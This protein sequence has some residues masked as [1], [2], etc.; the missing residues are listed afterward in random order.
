MASKLKGRAPFS[1]RQQRF[2]FAQARDGTPW[3]RKKLADDATLKV[4]PKGAPAPRPDPKYDASKKELAAKR[5]RRRRG[6][7]VT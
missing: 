5:P 7:R 6:K 2:F 4:Q 1:R 3:A